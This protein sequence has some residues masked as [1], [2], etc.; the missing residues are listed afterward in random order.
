MPPSTGSPRLRSSSTVEN[1]RSSWPS[2]MVQGNPTAKSGEQDAGHQ[3]KPVWRDRQP[4]RLGRIDDLQLD[5]VGLGIGGLGEVGGLQA[6]EQFLVVLAQHAVV[7]VHVLVLGHQARLLALHLLQ[8]SQ[9]FSRGVTLALQR[10]DGGI[11]LDQPDLELLDRPGSSTERLPPPAAPSALPARLPAGAVPSRD[12]LSD[13]ISFFCAITSGCCSVSLQQQQPELLLGLLQ[14]G[15]RRLTA[16]RRRSCLSATS[17]A[18]VFGKFL[19]S[20]SR[21]ITRILQLAV[22][23]P[24][25]V[26]GG[27]R[28]RGTVGRD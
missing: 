1:D 15:P 22:D 11:G 18:G 13:S 19:R 28:R 6:I 12:A 17:I 7:A 10:G 5:L 8:P 23:I 26:A 2:R 14:L 20:A 24:H 16:R 9:E 21:V 3:Q 4:R 27:F 25:A